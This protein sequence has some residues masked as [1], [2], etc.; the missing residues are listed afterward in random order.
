[1]AVRDESEGRFFL[2][3]NTMAVME[4]TFA[5]IVN[6]RR[7]ISFG[8]RMEMYSAGR[9]QISDVDNVLYHA[10]FDRDFI[11]KCA[12]QYGWNFAAII[13]SL[14]DGSFGLRKV[15]KPIRREIDACKRQLIR[16]AVVC[17]YMV[18]QYPYP[19]YAISFA[20]ALKRD[21][22]V[23]SSTTPASPSIA[24]FSK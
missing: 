8:G 1:M 19:E 11:E 3:R 4:R 17:S 22:W 21:G 13:R 23:S 15:Q 5:Q 12:Y 16:L 14:E 18:A 24:P 6:T 20:E 7:G 9:W 10:D 2:S